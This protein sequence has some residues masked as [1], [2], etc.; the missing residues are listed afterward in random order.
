LADY[1]SYCAHGIDTNGG[2]CSK[3]ADIERQNKHAQK[4][5]GEKLWEDPKQTLQ[6]AIERC[7]RIHQAGIQEWVLK[8]RNLMADENYR[9]AYDVIS[10]GPNFDKFSGWNDRADMRALGAARYP[11]SR[12]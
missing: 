6:D 3:C 12:Y 9:E 5:H 4:V 11:G 7:L 1:S 10:R 2:Y 8:C